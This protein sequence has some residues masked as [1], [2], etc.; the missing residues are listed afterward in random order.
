MKTVHRCLALAAT[1]VCLGTASAQTEEHRATRLGS[2]ATR[3]TPALRTPEDLRALFRDPLL[4]PDVASILA[5]WGWKG[6]PA[7]LHAAAL[8]NTIAELELPVGTR[9][10]FMSSR[11]SGK[12]V[13]LR[14]VLWAGK[15]P[16]AAYA[17]TF[18]SNGRLYR[19]VTPKPCG[20]F[21]L[22][23]LGAPE[24]VLECETPAQALMGRPVQV[25]LI[26]RNRG[27]AA[28]PRTAVALPIPDAAAYVNAV[29]GSKTFAPGDLNW[30]ILDL[31]AGGTQRLSAVFTMTQPGS[32]TFAATARGKFSPATDSTCSTRI[33][34]IPAVLL[35]V[36]DLDDPVEVGDEVTYD[37]K[38]TNQGSAAL[39]NVRLDCTLPASQQYL[40]GDGITGVDFRDGQA[41]TEPLPH[42]APKGVAAWQ[43]RVKVLAPDDARFEV[44]LRSE[45]FEKPIHENES[46]RQF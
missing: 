21:Y 17:F 26:L 1:L 34:G 46:T 27:D 38:V 10:P 43:V 15:E 45:E 35:E 39:T 20:N 19:C 33:V 24:I 25:D 7:D 18:Q 42:L 36:I 41:A 8:T 32:L 44:D 30:E 37:I 4:K 2:P 14:N 5:Q 16:V 9:M 29:D 13:C 23:D 6:N 12:P 40:S 3:F 22:E 28:E 31:P 11:H